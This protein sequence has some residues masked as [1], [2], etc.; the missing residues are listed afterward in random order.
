MRKINHGI[1][2]FIIA[3][4]VTNTPPL[5][6][7]PIRIWGQNNENVINWKKLSRP[8]KTLHC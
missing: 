7:N 4:A 5:L 8:R 1:Y 2:N 3:N 6:D